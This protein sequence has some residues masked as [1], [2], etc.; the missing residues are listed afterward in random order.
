MHESIGSYRQAKALAEQ[1]L[2]ARGST[3]D[4]QTAEV[5]V[6]LARA[7]HGWV[8][9]KPR[10]RQRSRRWTFVSDCWVRMTWRSVPF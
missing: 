8:S 1:A 4:L 6:S 9:L 10:A 3:E 5:L 2:A 7:S